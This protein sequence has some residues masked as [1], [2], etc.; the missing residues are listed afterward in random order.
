MQLC[1]LCDTPVLNDGSKHF[2]LKQG[3]ERDKPD[4][5]Q[6][7]LL[8]QILWQITAILL[9]SG[10]AATLIINLAIQGKV[11]WSVYPI[12]V[13]LMI[14]SY[15]ALISLWHAQM[16]FQLVGGWI[17]SVIVLV[18]VNVL[19]NADWPLLLALP[20]LCA[21]NIIALLLNFVVKALKSK[22]LNVFAIII[23]AI[24]LL[25]LVIEGIIS[26]YFENVIKLQWSA[27]VSAC[28]LPVTAAILFMYFRTRNN[29]DLK[30]IF[31][32]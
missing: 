6:K 19:I 27:V 12:S 15:V 4:I 13:C 10:I 2:I 23:L 25:C 16:V 11:T 30:K 18:I 32:T 5:K 21:V 1:P 20:I 17:L 31:H 28:L 8:S 9:L 14:L 7:Y 22:G 24:A 26:S 29:S 3:R